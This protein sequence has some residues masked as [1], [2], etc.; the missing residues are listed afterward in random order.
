MLRMIRLITLAVFLASLTLAIAPT[1]SVY[2]GGIVV[3]SL[4][5]SFTPG[6]SQCTLREAIIN[7]NT[8]IDSTRG[9]CAPGSYGNDLVVFNL[10]GTIILHEPLPVLTDHFTLIAPSYGVG[11]TLNGNDRVGVFAVNSNINVSL[12]NLTIANGFAGGGGAINNKNGFVTIINSTLINNTAS[13]IGGAIFNNSGMI[14][15]S[16]SALVNNEAFVS[17]GA[18]YNLTG[19]ITISN[20]TFSDNA[21]SFS[22]GGVYNFGGNVTILNSTLHGSSSSFG[23]NGIH[24]DGGIITV[25][26]SI[27]ANSAGKNCSSAFSASSTTNLD[28]DGSCGARFTITSNLRLAALAYNGGR[29]QTFALKIGSDGIN[30]GDL[31]TCASDFIGNLDQ[32]SAARV[33][34]C[35]IGAY[36][37]P[38]ATVGISLTTPSATVNSGD[39]VR[40]IAQLFSRGGSPSGTVTFKEGTATLGVIDVS[41][42]GQAMLILPSLSVGEHLI[43]ATYNG[44]AEF[45]IGVARELVITVEP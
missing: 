40:L 20:S 32:R 5:D 4:A 19:A 13:Q 31:L 29:T 27:V 6:N 41:T 22:G 44:D 34:N 42:G 25:K 30:S 1:S 10:H 35:D 37:S 11:I 33:H 45:N 14:T 9:D 26:N 38:Y 3:N 15:L 12:Q 39:E 18:I 21:A 36:E 43:S 2:G 7:A 16:N 28:T 17:G 8:N 24:S 23:G